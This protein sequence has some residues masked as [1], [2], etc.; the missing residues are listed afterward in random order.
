MLLHSE[1]T[2]GTKQRLF[3]TSSFSASLNSSSIFFLFLFCPNINLALSPPSI[4][5]PAYALYLFNSNCDLWSLYGIMMRIQNDKVL[6]CTPSP[7]PPSLISHSF[8]S[9]PLPVF[10]LHPVFHLK[11]SWSCFEQWVGHGDNLYHPVHW[12]AFFKL[13]SPPPPLLIIIILCGNT[14]IFLSLY[15]GPMKRQ[16]PQTWNLF[17]AKVASW[18]NN[19]NVSLMLYIS[20]YITVYFVCLYLKFRPLI[21]DQIIMLAECWW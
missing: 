3:Q 9:F 6:F 19:N 12:K 7:S 21:H 10:L 13:Q 16:N 20:L 14:H 1:F 18:I 4:Y 2:Y 11:L 8:S 5:S 15:N 17:C